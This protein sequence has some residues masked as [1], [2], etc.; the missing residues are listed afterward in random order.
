[1]PYKKRISM[2]PLRI[3]AIDPDKRFVSE[4]T[5]AF[6]NDTAFS[7]SSAS[8]YKEALNFF[9]KG[10]PDIVVSELEL[11][12]SDGM[13]IID[14]IKSALSGK[15]LISI[16]TKVKDHYSQITVLN[17]GA[18][19][20]M[21]KPINPRLLKKRLLGLARR[22]ST[23]GDEDVIEVGDVRIDYARYMVIRNNSKVELRKKE[24]E[25]VDLL[26]KDPNKVFTREEIKQ[27][28]WSDFDDVRNRTIDVHIRK[29][30][31]K[32]GD[33]FIHTIKGVG[34]RL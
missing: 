26:A 12:D 22:L 4:L 9:T 11:P 32:L 29:L 2:N 20:F 5:E 3:L 28:L 31:S 10:T 21:T 14:Y 16:L 6:E 27:Q 17:H 30:R 1:M 23:H 13:E 24:F 15:P 7:F 33:D 34:Y 25:I 8:S 18:D 19:D